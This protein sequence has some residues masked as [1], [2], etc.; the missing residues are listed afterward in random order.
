MK[1]ILGREIPEFIEGYGQV[2]PFKGAYASIDSR[3]R[4]TIPRRSVKPGDKLESG[5]AKL[6]A[7]IEE[8]VEK[9]GLKDGM[10][11]SFHHHLR[12]GDYVTNMVMKVIADKGIK[13]IHVA[14][15]GIFACHEPLV[16]YIK[17]G[18][19][20]AISVNYISPG[21]VAKAITKG[22][23]PKPAVFRSHGGRPR[24]VEAGDLHVDVAFIAAP[25]CDDYGNING[26]QGKSACGVLS[27]IYPDAQYADQVVAV[28]DN[29][30]PYP[31]C[32]IEISQDFVDYVVVVDSIGD[33]NGIV[34]GTTKVTSENRGGRRRTY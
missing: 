22:L 14:A 1:N 15:T 5:D 16:E 28:T 13:D 21:P 17:S 7:S 20:T 24:A 6:L 26:T 18:V 10:T 33:P 23:L 34:S 29:L 2:K 12:N 3:T 25:C 32:P 30:V 27:Y 4:T 31:A 11:V 9:T 19:I 8:A